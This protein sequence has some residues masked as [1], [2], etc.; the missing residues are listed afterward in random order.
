[1]QRFL[2]LLFLGFGVSKVSGQD[3][4]VAGKGP[5]VCG[6]L[7][8]SG[9]QAFKSTILAEMYR[10]PALRA[11]NKKYRVPVVVHVIE[12]SRSGQLISDSAIYEG[13][14]NLNNAFS[15]SASFAGSID[16]GIEF[17]LA[18]FDPNCR[19]TNGITR[20]DASRIDWYVRAG[21]PY[22]SFRYV[23][24]W[25]NWDQ[26]YYL[27]IWLVS[28]FDKVAG[29]ASADVGAAVLASSFASGGVVPHEVG[30]YLGLAH[31]FPAQT[32]AC[33]CGDGDGLADTP[34]LMSY[35][36]ES[37]C[38]FVP[39]C[40][41]AESAEVNLCTGKPLGDIQKN[42]MN[43][44]CQEQFTPDQR[45]LMRGMLETYHVSLLSSPALS[46][47]QP[48]LIAS[49]TGPSLV[50][51][52]KSTYGVVGL[53]AI[54]S[55][56]AVPEMLTID[57]KPAEMRELMIV[58][59]LQFGG[60]VL[61]TYEVTCSNGYSA[62]KTVRFQRVGVVNIRRVCTSAHTYAVTFDNP[63]QF[64]ISAS[65]GTVSGNSVINIPNDREVFLKA[66]ASNG[67][68]DSVLLE[69]P[70]CGAGLIVN[71]KCIPVASHILKDGYG[72][73]NFTFGSSINKSSS[74]SAMDAA[75]Y[76]DY[77]CSEQATVRAGES[78]AISVKGFSANK[79]FVKVDIDF[80]AD[81]DL[82]GVGEAVLTGE[83]AGGTANVFSGQVVIP[84][85]AV[86][87]KKLRMRVLADTSRVSGGCE[88]R[89]TEGAGSGQI[90]DYSIYIQALPEPGNPGPDFSEIVKIKINHLPDWAVRVKPFVLPN[91]VEGGQFD[92][93]IPDI[94]SYYIKLFM[95][96]GE[97]VPISIRQSSSS[98][99]LRISGRSKLS[100]GLY[101]LKIKREENSAEQDV[102]VVVL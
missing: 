80:D 74:S 38:S 8:D 60:T 59:S 13:I 35:G 61:R 34:D 100:P 84:K 46:E 14:R 56:N 37:T 93:V 31:P 95:R 64:V 73:E 6:V 21:L 62:S 17:E 1:M 82:N 54:C 92:L 85:H 78:Y 4:L 42:F 90:E 77:A 22:L 58:P 97:Q 33:G 47:T 44:S 81:G 15:A 91:P 10:H 63:Y 16:T 43:Y 32:G 41:L 83:T 72:I 52:T 2:L 24:D 67:L 20:Y 45:S 40:G 71:A 27:N 30:H 98:N 49:I 65:T 57:E 79:Y 3:V 87:Q 69:A 5:I 50:Y 29:V 23:K 99:Q 19:P 89:D 102:K 18:R 86:T 70:C 94:G 53:K 25:D 68:K 48:S 76:L 9:A 7:S 12:P 55:C 66:E 11:G 88:I 36:I 101:I 75:Y 28:T 39:G 96:N 26:N 51:T